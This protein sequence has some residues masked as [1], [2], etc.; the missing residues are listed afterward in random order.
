MKEK[1]SKLIDVKTIV[2]LALIFTLVYIVVTGSKMDD[3]VF[4][5]F[6]NVTTGIVTYFFTRKANEQK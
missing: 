1:L 6:S 2:T 3:K 4:A 5:L